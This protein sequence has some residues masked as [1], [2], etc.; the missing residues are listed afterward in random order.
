MQLF[1][2]PAAALPQDSSVRICG[3]GVSDPLR[4]SGQGPSSVQGGMIT[5][6]GNHK[7]THAGTQ[8]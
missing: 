5:K 7:Q 8:T 4:L 2:P 1:L 3:R 6:G